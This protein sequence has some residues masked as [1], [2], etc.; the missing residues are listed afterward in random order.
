MGAFRVRRE[1][2]NPA[3][4]RF[5]SIEALVDTGATY[6]VLPPDLL[7]RLGIRPEEEWRSCWPTDG[8]PRIASGGFR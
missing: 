1:V 7:E 4:G 5:E 2:G 6:T 3:G 8:R